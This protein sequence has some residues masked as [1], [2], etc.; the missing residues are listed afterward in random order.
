VP[1]CQRSSRSLTYSVSRPEFPDA[2]L[3]Q[4][5][6]ARGKRKD[7]E[8]EHLV[9]GKVG[10]WNCLRTAKAGR[11]HACGSSPFSQPGKRGPAVVRLEAASGALRCALRSTPPRRT[12]TP[13][14][15]QDGTTKRQR[16]PQSRGS[17][18]V[19]RVCRP[20][21]RAVAANILSDVQGFCACPKS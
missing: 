2:A 15:G 11:R 6:C 16:R 10:S 18:R 8:R 19:V 21:A 5:A 7:R 13:P 20:P 4:I 17:C 1:R 12:D 9:T 3:V 14:P